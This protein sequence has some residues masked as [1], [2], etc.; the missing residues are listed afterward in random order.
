[1]PQ[2]V[3][4]FVTNDAGLFHVAGHQTAQGSQVA[5]RGRA[6]MDEAVAKTVPAA[7]FLWCEM[8]YLKING[9]WQ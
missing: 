7:I 2:A 6:W 5:L 1:V 3:G 4:G 8:N 9:S